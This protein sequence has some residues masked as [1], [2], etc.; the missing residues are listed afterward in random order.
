MRLL[1]VMWVCVMCTHMHTITFLWKNC[2][3]TDAEM[4]VRLLRR[5]VVYASI[6]FFPK[7]RTT[8]FWWHFYYVLLSLFFNGFIETLHRTQ[9]EYSSICYC[10]LWAFNTL[11]W[12]KWN[13]SQFTTN[14]IERLMRWWKY[15]EKGKKNI[16]K[17]IQ[18]KS[19]IKFNIKLKLTVFVYS[20]I[21]F[22]TAIIQQIKIDFNFMYFCA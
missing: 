2:E 1:Y 5:W 20:F 13:N 9:T 7:R 4:C 17:K 12:N 19:S 11:Y 8:T 18:N 6:L 16:N 14:K 22:S 15:F 10:N 21:H 3:L